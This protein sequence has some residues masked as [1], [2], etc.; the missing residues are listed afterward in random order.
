MNNND[1]RLT[2]NAVLFLTFFLLT[3]VG[4]LCW[5]NMT[6]MAESDRWE[7]H[8][9]TVIREL[10]GFLAAMID[11]EN[12]QRGYIITGNPAFLEPYRA[13][14]SEID[15]HLA[16]F[17]SLTRDN[18]R[19]QQRLNV[20]EPLVRERMAVMKR[21]LDLHSTQGFP[22]AAKAMSTGE[23]REL[24]ARVRREVA[25][26]Q[27]EEERLLKERTAV[28]EA[29]TRKTIWSLAVGGLL[30]LT[31]LYLVFARLKRELQR[32]LKTEQELRMHQE[33][34]SDLVAERTRELSDV[35]VHLQNEIKERQAVE[36]AL[37]HSESRLRATF[38]NAGV[39]IVELDE[40]DRFIAVNDRLCQILELRREDLLGRTVHELT[41]PEDRPRSE[42]LS[43]QLHDGKLHRYDN[44]K[45]YLARNGERLW[46]HATVAAIRDAQGGYLRAIGTVEDISQRKA[47][48]AALRESERRYRLLVEASAQ[49]VW[50]VNAVGE[51]D[52]PMPAWQAYTGQSA[53]ETEGWGWLDAILPEDR[54]RVGEAWRRAVAQRDLY[55]VEYQLRRDDGVWRNM[56][57]RG[58]P[59]IEE[60]GSIREWIGA[61][62]DITERKR[63]EENLRRSEEKYRIIVESA[64]DY[65]I[66]TLDPQWRVITWSSGAQHLLGYPEGEALGRDMDFIFT[67]EAIQR[68]E[69]EADKQG[70]L[71]NG[72]T[73]NERWYQ[74]KDGSRFWGI[75]IMVALHDSE[76]R[77]IG[78]L[79][80]LQDLT[81]RK[82]LQEELERR[83]DER[84]AQLQESYQRLEGMN[85][86]LEASNRELQDFAFVASHDLQE[87][88]RKIMAFGDVLVSEHQAALGESGADYLRRMQS[89]ARRM[90]ALI[91]DLL[92]F[93]RVTTK[94]QPFTPVDL[95]QVAEDVLGDLEIRV[96]QS[97]GRVEV[98]ALP[99]IEADPIQMRQ[100]LQNLVGNALKFA[101]PEAPPLVRI[102]AE[103]DM[104]A[105]PGTR[106]QNGSP[107]GRR[108]RLCVADNGIG[109]DEKYLDRIFTVFQRLH[110]R[111]VYEG[112]GIGLAI[113]RKIVERHGGSITA[114][115]RAG[116]GATFIASLPYQQ[117]PRR[118]GNDARPR[119]ADYDP[120]GG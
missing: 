60:D 26:A 69:P 106:P 85:R 3:A 92:Q 6:A 70:V 52:Q 11:A 2:V 46:V 117:T 94:A 49:V 18:P 44:E 28:K 87:P 79:K 58:V 59:V 17:R 63:A 71:E 8:T 109:F 19:Q 40:Q 99:K 93:S 42:S 35:N 61:C 20:L 114:R 30:A 55:E 7:N 65:A 36:D 12:G 22:D 119:A 112:T 24:M 101:R 56:Q 38:D 111:G 100:L 89:A 90:Q 25:Q 48:E 77:L 15:R 16:N 34:L 113:C 75:G 41:A 33:R 105:N 107:D 76:G 80:V 74:R 86:K 83:V 47:A 54:D 118:N 67:A 9:Y 50:R 73:K 13:S 97:G 110:E 10:D 108:F 57:A 51:A 32:R 104:D 31:A 95:R 23:G 115:S 72:R 27:T 103:A 45:R 5:R 64:M 21:T 53:E 116:E 4:L 84:T 1:R 98:G 96:R 39:G 102:Y 88:L 81:E 91:S 78:F 62:S 120:D 66:F 43:V 29:D 14:L 68:G 82:H 37:R